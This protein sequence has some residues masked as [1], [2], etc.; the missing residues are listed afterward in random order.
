M[1][2]NGLNQRLGKYSM[3]IRNVTS[4]GMDIIDNLEVQKDDIWRKN[5]H[6][7]F[8]RK[9]FPTCWTRYQNVSSVSGDVKIIKDLKV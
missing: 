8:E 4:I 2:S 9:A 5:F 6:E 3:G 7:S 1:W